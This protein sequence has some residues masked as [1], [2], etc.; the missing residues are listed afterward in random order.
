MLKSIVRRTYNIEVFSW[1]E[2]INSLNNDI[3][4]SLKREYTQTMGTEK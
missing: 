3:L 4:Q 2:W 1:D